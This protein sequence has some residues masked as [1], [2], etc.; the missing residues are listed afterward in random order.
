MYDP[1]EPMRIVTVIYYYTFLP[2][3]LQDLKTLMVGLLV[4]SKICS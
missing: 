1:T 4:Q 2:P 3:R